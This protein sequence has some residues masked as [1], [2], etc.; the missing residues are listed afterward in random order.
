VSHYL[1]VEASPTGKP[2]QAKDAL[3]IFPYVLVA[4]DIPGLFQEV[5]LFTQPPQAYHCDPPVTTQHKYL[6]A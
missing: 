5:V 2:G 1:W 6:S 3:S 4:L